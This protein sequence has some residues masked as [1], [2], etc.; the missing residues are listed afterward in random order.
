MVPIRS[1]RLEAMRAQLKGLVLPAVL[2]CLALA[3]LVSL[4][5]WQV[6]RLAWKEDLIARA[7]ERPA[8]APLDFRAETLP[9]VGDAAA[10]LERNEYRRMRVAGTYAGEGEVLV[11]TALERPRGPHGGPGHWVLTPFVTPHGVAVLVNRGFV[12]EHDTAAYSSPPAGQQT[13]GGLV[14]APET[15]SWLT[16]EPDLEGRV[17]FARDVLRI[18]AA[19]GLPGG[20]DGVSSLAPFFLDLEESYMPPSGL[21][22]AGETRMTFSN[23]HLQYAVTWYGLAAALLAVFAVFVRRRLKEPQQRRLTPTG[24]HP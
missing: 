14:R 16:P 9:D 6:H 18:G 7:Q 4:G 13:I 10:F 20:S 8:A 24:R 1:G 5:N 3:V 17:F 15:G 23:N 21:P 19:A 22:Q 11:F 2:V 12:P